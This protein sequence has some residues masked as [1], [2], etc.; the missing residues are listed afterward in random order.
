VKSEARRARRGPRRGVGSRPAS[1][2]TVALIDSGWSPRLEDPRVGP[3]FWITS[4][5]G[6]SI[7]WSPGAEDEIG[8]G[9]A[10][11]D[12]I[13]R[14]A[15][16]AHVVPIKVFRS[17]LETSPEILLAALELA[18]RL[19]VDVVNLSLGTR[20]ARATEPLFEACV[21]AAQRG[22]VVVAAANPRYPGIPAHFANVVGVGSDPEAAD[23]LEIT[24]QPGPSTDY[25]AKSTHDDLL[26]LEG[27]RGPGAG[28]SYAAPIIS[29]VIAA[30]RASQARRTSTRSSRVR[31]AEMVRSPGQTALREFLPWLVRPSGPT[32]QVSG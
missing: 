4:D 7:E 8:H 27:S 11:A 3:G 2:A 20:E 29:G 22:I 12:L 1:P 30:L 6:G 9:T 10:C 14:V 15:P 28:S 18:M 17:E 13:L 25:L 16:A 24:S 5:A 31:L 26:R 23:L 32:R 19:E 21:E